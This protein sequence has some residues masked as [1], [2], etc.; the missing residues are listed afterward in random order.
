M[1]NPNHD[2]RGRF[3]SGSEAAAG[4]GDHTAVSP[5]TATRNVPGHGTVARSN[6][7]ARHAGAVSLGTER[8]MSAK[9]E[10]RALNIRA[11]ASLYHKLDNPPGAHL[12]GSIIQPG[13]LNPANSTLVSGGPKPRIRVKAR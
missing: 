13:K 11:D 8:P 9:E 12:L 1:A 2:N 6:P 10:R 7:V 5:S 4:V 3:A